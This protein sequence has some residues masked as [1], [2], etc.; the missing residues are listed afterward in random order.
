MCVCVCVC[1]CVLMAEDQ[2]EQQLLGK[3]GTEKLEIELVTRQTRLVEEIYS[4]N[5]FFF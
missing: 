4:P 1:V 3:E 5:R 2:E